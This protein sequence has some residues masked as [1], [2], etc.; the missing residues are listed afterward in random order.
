MR[1]LSQAMLAYA[2]LL[3]VDTITINRDAR[4]ACGMVEEL[5][6]RQPSFLARLAFLVLCP[7]LTRLAAQLDE[8]LRMG[9]RVFIS[10]TPCTSPQSY[11]HT[12]H[13]T[14]VSLSCA[15]HVQPPALRKFARCRRIPTRWASP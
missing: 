6:V 9:F 1:R 15:H 4:L 12:H 5:L 13:V 2:R 10:A 3:K 7:D 8:G 11:F 14:Q